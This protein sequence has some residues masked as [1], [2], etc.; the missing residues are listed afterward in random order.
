MAH[1]DA[2]R[3]RILAVNL[4]VVVTMAILIAGS[5][6]DRSP[7]WWVWLAIFVPPVLA[8][9][10]AVFVDDRGTR[11][12]LYIAAAV[13]MLPAVAFGVFAGWGLLYAIAIAFLVVGA[14]S[15]DEG[16]RS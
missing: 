8:I 15:P 11:G 3:W 13:L 12:E 10:T 6:A 14:R 9:L 7:A 4:M 5:D 1:M 16:E 2:S